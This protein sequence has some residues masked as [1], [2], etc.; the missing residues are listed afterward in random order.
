M[1][2]PC[3]RRN[4]HKKS[5]RQRRRQSLSQHPARCYRR[6][7]LSSVH[8]RRR[9]SPP[10]PSQFPLKQSQRLSRL[11][12]NHTWLHSRPFYL[13][14]QEDLIPELSPRVASRTAPQLS[15]GMKLLNRARKGS[16]LPPKRL[17]KMEVGRNF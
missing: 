4:R 6:I 7:L 5:H 10:L 9:L 17:R 13:P 11:L 8:R 16:F 1:R 12:E 2:K 15:Q 14:Y 3:P